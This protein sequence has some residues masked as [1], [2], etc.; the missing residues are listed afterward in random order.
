M[1]KSPNTGCAQANRVLAAL[2]SLEIGHEIIECS[3]ELSDTKVFCD[4]YGYS[5]DQ[6]ANVI[7]AVGKTEPRQFAAC[8]LLA[9]SRLDINRCVRKR[10]GVRRASF[11]SSEET[12][13]MTG[14]E[15][16]GVTA[17]ALPESLPI[18]VDHR[19]MEPEFIILGGG[20]RSIKIKVSPNI[21]ERIDNTTIIENLASI[22]G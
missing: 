17:L 1:T 18:W 2:T 22:P 20:S 21:F 4:H 19:V 10:M 5:L 6:S 7:V 11:A 13:S 14:M 12:R 9:T 8:V 16:G 3:P 15:I